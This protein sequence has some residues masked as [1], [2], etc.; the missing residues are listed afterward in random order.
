[1]HFCHCDFLGLV[2]AET[3]LEQYED[4]IENEF[5]DITRVGQFLDLSDMGWLDAVEGGVSFINEGLGLG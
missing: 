5:D 1:M 3:K 2:T 4:T